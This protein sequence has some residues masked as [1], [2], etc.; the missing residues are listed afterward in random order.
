MLEEDG[1]F[2]IKNNDQG[3]CTRDENVR[4][5]LAFR[6]PWQLASQMSSPIKGGIERGNRGVC[7]HSSIKTTLTI[8][9]NIARVNTCNT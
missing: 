4:I 5:A 2:G 8:E 6:H 1:S 9:I 3:Y 7:P